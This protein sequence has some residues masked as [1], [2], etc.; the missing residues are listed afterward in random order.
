MIIDFNKMVEELGSIETL[1]TDFFSMSPMDQSAERD[2]GRRGRGG[3]RKGTCA[4][5]KT[6]LQDEPESVILREAV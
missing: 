5:V 1:K 2:E 3:V 6:E 4:A